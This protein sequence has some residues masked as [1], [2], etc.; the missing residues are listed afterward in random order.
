MKLTSFKVKKTHTSACWTFSFVSVLCRVEENTVLDTM[1]HK[2]SIYLWP[3]LHRITWKT[4]NKQTSSL[5]GTSVLLLGYTFH[6][7]GLVWPS[8]CAVF[9]NLLQ[10]LF[11]KIGMMRRP[12]CAA[13]AGV[14]APWAVCHPHSQVTHV[15]LHLL[16]F[17]A[18]C[19]GLHPRKLW[20]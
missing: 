3:K 2:V 15:L 5:D 20:A 17:T 8:Y 1:K 9:I 13:P 10:G 19:A 6:L 18:R 16:V 7:G 12:S 14:P 4:Q 11:E